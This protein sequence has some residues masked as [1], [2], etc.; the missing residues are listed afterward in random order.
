VGADLAAQLLGKAR[1]LVSGVLL[2]APDDDMASLVPLI[3][4][5]VG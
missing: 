4:A 2:A 5:A 3:D 1:P